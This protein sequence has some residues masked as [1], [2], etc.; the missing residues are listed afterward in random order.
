[1]D[2]LKNELPKTP[3]NKSFALLI[4][5]ASLG[6]A[7]AQA[8]P[9]LVIVVRHAE[10]AAE[11]R[12]DPG[13]SAEGVQRAQALADRLAETHVTSIITTELRRSRE[14]ALP[15]AMKFG[16]EP[17]VVAT[18]RDDVPAHVQAVVAAVRQL[19]GVVL[20]V[21]HSNTVAG[22]VAGLSDARPI[23]LCD[24]SHSHVFVV[25]PQPAGSAV[26]Q[27]TYGREDPAPSAGC[28]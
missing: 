2:G 13:L 8:Q 16:I 20:V 27:F 6:C 24:T 22:L 23:E 7:A 5:I 25:D 1:V 12:G 19:T 21:G 17:Q 14:T 4:A 3:V 10:R 9:S 26:L 11:P 15:T 28:Q 18:N